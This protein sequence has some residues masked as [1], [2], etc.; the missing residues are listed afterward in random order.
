MKLNINGQSREVSC[1][2]N[3]L[4][5]TV[6]RR[7]GLTGTKVGCGA[8]QCGAC[9]V[10]LD[11]QV[12]LSCVKKMSL[13][14][15]NAEIITIEGIGTPENLH[16]LQQAWIT[17]GGV[18]CGF[19]SP[20]FIVS[21]YQLLKENPSPTREEVR[22]CFSKN[23]NA[24]RCTGY[25]PLVDSVMKAAA[26]MRGELTMDDITYHAPE[27]GNYYGT[28]IPRPAALGRVTGL[29][30]YGDDYSL[31]SMPEDTLHLAVVLSEEAYGN[32]LSIDVTEAEAMPGVVKVLTAEDIQGDNS[33]FL[34]VM[35]MRSTCVGFEHQILNTDQVYHHGDVLALVCADTRD[36]ARAAAKLVKVEIEPL[37]PYETILESLA[38]D[39]EQ[40]HPDHPNMYIEQPLFKGE[41]T[42]KVLAYRL[43]L[44]LKRSVYELEVQWCKKVAHDHQKNAAR[45]AQSYG[46]MNCLLELVITACSE[47]LGHYNAGSHRHAAEKTHKACY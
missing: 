5:S 9:S 2:G 18:Q 12:I 11:G 38:P 1:E 30:D 15:E 7:I 40:I 33:I 19:C 3:E 32:L 37:A 25:K 29:C 10:I 24:C 26:V 44:Q 46:I 34:P 6:L 23:K 47:L 42:R 39:A 45:K 14:P 20:G 22:T 35:H 13:I 43:R 21:A 17:Y 16:P 4:L 31:K 41:D 36:H 27:D 8:G 28:S